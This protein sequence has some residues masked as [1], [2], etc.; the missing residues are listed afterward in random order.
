MKSSRVLLIVLALALGVCGEAL[1]QPRYSPPDGAF[2]ITLPPDFVPIPALELYLFEHHGHSGPVTPQ[3]LAEF[4]NTRMGFQKPSEKWF[5]LPYVII[6]VEK[7]RKRG[8]QDLFMES[9]MAE[10]D[11]EAGASQDGYHF[12]AKEH[13]PMKRV[14]YYKDISYSAAQGK[15]VAM[16][17]YTYLTS[18]GFLRVAWFAGEDQLPEFER[19]L[20]NAAMSVQL[21]PEMVYKPEGKK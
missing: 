11:S 10:R 12:L 8:P 1:A 7:G 14:T 20:H 19:A 2:S 5:T 4:K 15:K 18:Q 17:V 9:V 16:G 21:S 3:A 6:T 13:L